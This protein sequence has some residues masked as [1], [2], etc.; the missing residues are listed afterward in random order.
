MASGETESSVWDE[1]VE[2]DP[3]F[4]CPVGYG[5]GQA[6]EGFWRDVFAHA[7]PGAR[8]L[9]IGCGSGQ[10]SIW[11]EEA[12]RGMRIVATDVHSRA[13]E[14]SAHPGL[15]FQ[16]GVRAEALPF[17]PATFDLAVSNFAFEYADPQK[18]APELARVLA[19]GGGAVMVMH[20]ADSEISASSRLMI[21]IEHRLAEA[22]VSDQIRRAAGLRRDHL[23]RRKLLK[24]VLGQRAQIPPAA[25]NF[26][27]AEY[28]A[29]AE[30]LLKGEAVAAAE[31]DRIDRGMAMRLAMAQE[32]ARAALDPGRLQALLALFQTTGLAAEATE[33]C[34]TYP[35]GQVDRVGWIAL[36][37]KP[38]AR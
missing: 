33:L 29:L 6:L 20:R 27:G 10:V 26:S 34:C 23:S 28:F 1:R 15:A 35:G 37:T 5:A 3:T 16:G 13:G 14:L 19:P 12:Q 11:A 31:I 38:P 24:Q 2:G 18:A 32:Q 8:V 25:F 22:A 36:L 9:E 21:E 4:C 17:P 7:R 30:R